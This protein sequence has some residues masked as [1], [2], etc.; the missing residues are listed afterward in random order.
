MFSNVELEKPFVLQIECDNQLNGSVVYES[1]ECHLTH[2]LRRLVLF[3]NECLTTFRHEKGISTVLNAEM[4]EFQRVRTRLLAFLEKR[5]TGFRFH[6][7][8]NRPD[9]GLEK[10]LLLLDRVIIHP[11]KLILYLALAL[12]NNFKKRYSPLKLGSFLDLLPLILTWRLSGRVV[13]HVFCFSQENLNKVIFLCFE[14]N[15][16]S[17]SSV[18]D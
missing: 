2:R 14:N 8:F 17:L 15:L 11:I 1:L 9:G 16:S 5:L 6:F 3:F 18:F 13:T 7:P 12:L 4:D 10:L